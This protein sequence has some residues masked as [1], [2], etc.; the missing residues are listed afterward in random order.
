MRFQKHFLIALIA[1]VT[2][3]SCKKKNPQEETDNLF[4]FKE[5]INYATSGVVSTDSDI[6]IGLAKEIEGWEPGG[7]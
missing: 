2:I 3:A 1:L 5:Y 4:K 6:Q 7:N